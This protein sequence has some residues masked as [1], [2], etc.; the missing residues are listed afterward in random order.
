MKPNATVGRI[1]QL[2]LAIPPT[3][4]SLLVLFAIEEL[5]RQRILYGSLVASAFLIY[6]DPRHPMNGLR[7]MALGHLAACAIGVGAGV[8]IGAGYLAGG[9]AVV[10]TAALLIG[11]GQLHPP[12]VT[13]ALGFAFF[14]QEER[15][16]RVFLVALLILTALILMQRTGLV[17]LQWLEARAAARREMPVS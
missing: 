16:V 9:V 8:A 3:V 5:T 12:A 7:P 17:G 14:V 2:A 15:S 4:T 11:L 1:G 10:L 6:R 13:T